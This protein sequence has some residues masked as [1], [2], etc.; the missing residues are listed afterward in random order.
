MTRPSECQS[1]QHSGTIWPTQ[2]DGLASDH[3]SHRADLT[4]LN[5]QWAGLPPVEGWPSLKLCLHTGLASLVPPHRACAF[6]LGWPSLVPSHW[7]GQPT[8]TLGLCL[9]T[10]MDSLPSVHHI[11]QPVPTE[12]SFPWGSRRQL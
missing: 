9:H 3:A 4:C 1:G 11:E 12:T 6:T 2:W 8:L 10:G 5:L 7:D